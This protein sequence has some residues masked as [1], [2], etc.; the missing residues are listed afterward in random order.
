MALTLAAGI[1]LCGSGWQYGKIM[2][3]IQ[4]GHSYLTPL[5]KSVEGLKLEGALLV[6]YQAVPVLHLYREDLKTIGYDKDWSV[7]RLR[8]EMKRTGAARLMFCEESFCRSLG[9]D[10]ER[11]RVVDRQGP[12]G[13]VLY[14]AEVAGR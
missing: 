11:A 5:L 8:G 9:T 10:I 6:P 13:E 7:E 2:R 14:L 1:S 4:S 12:N 3:E